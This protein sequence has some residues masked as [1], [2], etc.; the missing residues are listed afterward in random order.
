MIRYLYAVAAAVFGISATLMLYYRPQSVWGRWYLIV[1]IIM[2]F[3]CFDATLKA[4]N[5]MKARNADN[6]GIGACDR[7]DKDGNSKNASAAADADADNAASGNDHA[8]GINT[9]ADAG[10]GVDAGMVALADKNAGADASKSGNGNGNA[11]EGIIADDDAY[12]ISDDADG[13]GGSDTVGSDGDESADIPKHGSEK[14]AIENENGDETEA[15]DTV[16]TVHHP[17]ERLPQ[18][19]PETEPGSLRSKIGE[20]P[21]VCGAGMA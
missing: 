6:A 2:V 14:Q 19:Q 5:A 10:A 9:D 3:L 21:G 16:R 15:E 1:T 18:Q 11:D 13:D 20:N 4:R 17:Q 12:T 7:S 8:D